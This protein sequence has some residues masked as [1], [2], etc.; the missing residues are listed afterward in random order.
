MPKFYYDIFGSASINLKHEMGPFSIS[1]LG[2]TR[3]EWTGLKQNY[4]NGQVQGLRTSKA[5]TYK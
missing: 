3:G 5:Q 1:V 4:L 2:R